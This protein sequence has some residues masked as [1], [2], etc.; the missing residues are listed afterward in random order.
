M[1]RKHDLRS[2][3]HALRRLHQTLVDV[4][5]RDYE[6]EWGAVAP[7]ELLQ[8]LTKHPGFEWLRVL[9]QLMVSIDELID[10]DNVENQEMHTV[11]TQTRT[12]I[13]NPDSVSSPFS[14][15]YR[16]VLQK[17]PLIV[18]EHAAVHRQLEHIRSAFGLVK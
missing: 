5:R 12:L 13:L 16:D 11:Y 10:Q 2:L 4:A 6:K 17:E 9:S 1:D 14:E 18:M 3:T 8:L 7:G 15:R